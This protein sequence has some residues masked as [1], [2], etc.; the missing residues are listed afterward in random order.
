MALETSIWGVR[1]GQQVR[2]AIVG[3]DLDTA[4]RLARH[5]DG[6]TRDLAREYAF[7]ARGLVLTLRSMLPMLVVRAGEGSDS[8]T[9]T[10]PDERL[11]DVLLRFLEACGEPQS[12][13]D[14]AP[15][16]DAGRASLAD[17]RLAS[18]ADGCLRA[19]DKGHRAFIDDQ[20]DS[21]E[22]VLAALAA[23]DTQAALELLDARDQDWLARHDPMVLLM[24][25]GFAWVMNHFGEPGLLEFHLGLAEAQRSGFEAWER[26]PAEEFAAVTAFLLKQHMGE[27]RVEE[28]QRR[29]T[30]RQSP[31][32][33]GGRLRIGGAYEGQ[34]PLPFAETPGPLTF[35]ESRMPVYCTHCAIWNGSA[36]L[37]WFGR[38]QWVFDEPARADGGCTLY[39][40]KRPEDAPADYTRRV[41]LGSNPPSS[42]QTRTT[43]LP[44]LGRTQ[45]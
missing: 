25:E 2:Q 12:E 44:H 11:A 41:S 5:G 26:M 30:I 37:R 1:L 32:G 43:S 34:R 24:A 15:L 40:Y 9:A 35:G 22:A 38:A 4:C 7:M 6:Q 29:F 3:G 23:Y 18:L 21:G 45:S 13:L 36:T 42:T 39:I 28:D 20:A 14:H 31:C 33:S 27:V 10:I 19:L 8:T 16:A 17:T